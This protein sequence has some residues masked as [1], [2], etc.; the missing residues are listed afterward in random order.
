MHVVAEANYDNVFEADQGVLFDSVRQDKVIYNVPPA[1]RN[2]A[3]RLGVLEWLGDNF[4]G[5]QIQKIAKMPKN[6][7]RTEPRSIEA[8]FK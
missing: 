2:L 4:G 7:I 6:W 5:P 1:G 3:Q 8:Q